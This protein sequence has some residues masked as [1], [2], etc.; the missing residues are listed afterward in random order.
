M[1]LKSSSALQTF[2]RTLAALLLLPFTTLSSAQQAETTATI[3]VHADQPD[4]QMI[5]IWN[6]FGYDEP[7]YTY[8][9]T[10]RNYSPNSQ[11]PVPHRST[12]ASTIF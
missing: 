10:A 5:P 6:Y 2:S 7:N 9:P 11:P 3:E 12:F 1:P 4:G 8:A